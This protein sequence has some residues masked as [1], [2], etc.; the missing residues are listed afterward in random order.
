MLSER[1]KLPGILS[2]QIET[3]RLNV[4]ILTSGPPAGTAV[5]F[6]HGNCSS[7]GIWDE[8]MLAL[9]EGYYGIAPDLRGHGTTEALPIDATLG[10]DDMVTDVRS[11]VE[12]LG[13][14]PFHIVGHGMGGGIAMKYGIAFSEQLQSITLIS[15]ISPFGFGGSK[16]VQGTPVYADGAPAGA[17]SVNPDFVRLLKE[18]E[19]GDEEPMAPLNV[20]RQFYLKPPFVPEREEAL[21]EAMLST[22]VGDDW[23]PG[24]S[25]PSANWPGTAPGTRGVVNASSRRYFDASAF[26]DIVPKPPVLWIRGADDLLISDRSLWEIACLGAMNFVPGWPGEDEVPPQPMVQ[27]TRALLERFAANGGEFKE[28]AIED[29]SHCPFIE[30]AEEFRSAFHAHL[31]ASE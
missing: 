22:K 24:T 29:A 10:L 21:L 7:A 28:I 16:D 12:S 13:L 9:P 1:I 31:K 18:K 27:Q 2:R 30:H 8:T 26:A 6:L 4:H 3:E 14:S 5:L 15:T 19:M 25:I 17:A 20:I 23:Y 11:L